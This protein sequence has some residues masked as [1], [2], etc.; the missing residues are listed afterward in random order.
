MRNLVSGV[1]HG[2]WSAMIETC[3]PVSIGWKPV[4]YAQFWLPPQISRSAAHIT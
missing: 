4:D 1:L 3:A 2:Q